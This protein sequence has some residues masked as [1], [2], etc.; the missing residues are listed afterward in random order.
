MLVNG[1]RI[2]GDALGGG[3]ESPGNPVRNHPV[4]FVNVESE[5]T[6]G[7]RM[8]ANRTHCGR[9]NWGHQRITAVLERVTDGVLC[10]VL[11]VGGDE[12]SETRGGDLGAESSVVGELDAK[13]SHCSR[14]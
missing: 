8:D 2:E 12:L 6:H 4:T 11:I 13:K 9:R 7:G 14:F 3:G 1:M 5:F 10:V